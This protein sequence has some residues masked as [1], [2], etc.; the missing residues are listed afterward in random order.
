MEQI[1]R[2]IYHVCSPPWD[3]PITLTA[4]RD[5]SQLATGDDMFDKRSW[6]LIDQTS[7]G[8]LD[9]AIAF[10]ANRLSPRAATAGLLHS[11]FETT[12]IGRGGSLAPLP[13]YCAAA[14]LTLYPYKVCTPCLS[15]Q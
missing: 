15:P 6:E 5:L 8:P 2:P 7:N 1:S 9:G 10:Q 3:M 12:A 4:G 14:V 13:A 11:S